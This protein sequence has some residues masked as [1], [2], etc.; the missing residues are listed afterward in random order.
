M[1]DQQ[2]HIPQVSV[3][4]G[5]AISSVFLQVV[6][7]FL[8]KLSQDPR[9]WNM[10]RG[11]VEDGFRGEKQVIE[12]ELNPWRDPGQRLFLDLGC[13]TGLFA[14]CF[15]AGYYI[16]VDPAPYYV[17]YADKTGQGSY[18]VMDGVS[19][20]LRDASF[21]AALVLGVLHHLPDPVVQAV[22]AELYRALK[23]GATLLVMEDI[24]PPPGSW[25]LGGRVMHWLDR[26]GFI[27]DDAD[28]QR[29]LSPLFVPHKQ[30]AIRSGICDYAVYVMERNA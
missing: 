8:D 2:P 18:A 20:G 1:G 15:P 24:E 11:F 3:A 22:V 14:P 16:G 29:L 6:Q 25:N 23:P 19:L 5:G 26:G 28:Y 9:A 12:R 21:D 27:R 30:Y 7:P 10:L 17:G 4:R 13:G